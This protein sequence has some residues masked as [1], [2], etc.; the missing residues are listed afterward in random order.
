MA[1]ATGSHP[2]TGS[3]VRPL[4]GSTNNDT[5]GRRPVLQHAENAPLDRKRLRFGLP[6]CGHRESTA[7]PWLRQLTRPETASAGIMGPAGV[8]P[9]IRPP[10]TQRIL[11]VNGGRSGTPTMRRLGSRGRSD[12]GFQ[13]LA[14]S[15]ERWMYESSG[16]RRSCGTSR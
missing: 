5:P 6:G 3:S 2:D 4:P 16:C 10:V 15:D 13:H 9:A 11:R 7:A 8:A 12:T 14:S 1:S